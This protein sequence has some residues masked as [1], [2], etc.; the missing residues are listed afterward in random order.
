VYTT[1]KYKPEKI[2]AWFVKQVTDARR[3]GDVDKEK[4]I[5]AEIFKLLGNNSYG[6]MIEALERR[7]TKAEKTVDHAL[8]SAWFEDLTEI[9]DVYEITSRKRRV[10]IHRPFQVGIAVYQLAKLR[11]LEFYHDF[12]DH[13]VDRKDFELIEMDSDTLY[14]ALS[15]NKID[16]VVRPELKAE[17]DNRK[18]DWLAWD[19]WSNRTPGLFKLEFEGHRAIALCSKCYFVD[20]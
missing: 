3:M 20:G 8:C 18:N 5:F 1:I 17:F 19:T 12:L 7:Y 14:F 9:G 10:T 11:I 16:D 13:F 4:A 6:K 15:P 2:L